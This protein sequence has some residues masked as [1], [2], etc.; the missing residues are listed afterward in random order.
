MEVPAVDITDLKRA[1]LVNADATWNKP[2]G[3][4]QT[5]RDLL[6][7]LCSPETDVDA[8]AARV[9][10]LEKLV[11]EAVLKAATEPLDLPFY[12]MALKR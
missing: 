11:Q 8:V 4:V 5:G 12:N 10:Y 6:T 3:T 1:W 9:W 2:P 7:Q